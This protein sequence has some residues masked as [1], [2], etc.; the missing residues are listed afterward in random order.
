MRP[1][2]DL[3]GTISPHSRSRAGGLEQEKGAAASAGAPFSRR[4]GSPDMTRT[5]DPLVN[6]QLLYRLSY[7]G[8]SRCKNRKPDINGK[9]APC[10]ER[11]FVTQDLFLS[12][13]LQLVQTVS[14]LMGTPVF[15]LIHLSW[16]SGAKY[17]PHLSQATILKDL[18][19]I[20][21]R[22]PEDSIFT[23]PVGHT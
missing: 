12:A 11:S 14:L 20:T 15:L 21:R 3:L 13:Y 23:N 1:L 2:R 18:S 6:S 10:Q 17:R 16:S 5:C 4:N 22:S 19:Q 8:M 9:T 7:R